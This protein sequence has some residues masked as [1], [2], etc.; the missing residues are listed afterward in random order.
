M[1]RS[2]R[3]SAS[4][5]GHVEIRSKRWRRLLTQKRRAALAIFVAVLGTSC[6]K[7]AAEY[8][9]TGPDST[10]SGA[11]SRPRASQLARQKH[12]RLSRSDRRALLGKAASFAYRLHTVK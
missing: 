9:A 6:A 10:G 12:R 5:G 3:A 11:S 2:L 8:A 7:T 4:R 1:R